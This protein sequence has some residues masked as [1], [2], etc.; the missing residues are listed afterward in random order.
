[1]LFLAPLSLYLPPIHSPS[2]VL[3]CSSSK[4][5]VRSQ[6]GIRLP[7]AP[8][9]SNGYVTGGRSS[10]RTP[11]KVYRRLDSCLV[12][13]PPS[14]RQPLAVVKF[15]G[16][17]FVGAAPELTYSLLMEL[18]AKEGF[19]IVS[20]PYGVT[21]DHSA[22]AREVHERF[23]SCMNYLLS[24][25]VPQSGITGSELHGL[26]FYSVG[27]SNGALLQMLVGSFFSEKIPKANVVIS[28]C[29]KPASQAVPYFEQ[30]GPIARQ[31]MPL[32]EASPAYSMA[33]I[34]LGLPLISFV[35]ALE[36]LGDAW[37]A[38]VHSAETSLQDL[39]QEIFT[40]L[41]KF[42][43]QLPSVFGQVTQG[44]SEFSPTPME[45]R[46]FFKKAYS[47]PHTL[48]VKFKIDGIDES[49][50]LEKVLKPRAKSIGGNVEKVVLSGNHLTP[51]IQD[52][53]W[54]VGY[55]YTPVDA[56]AQSLKS[57][58]LNE[59]KLLAATIA[60][61]LKSLDKVN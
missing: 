11:E 46:E 20:V 31:L 22:A 45:N 34:A 16:G 7:L 38:L 60:D 28:F 55:H 17:A 48:L 4:S 59:T 3:L 57:L 39:D 25:G 35:F 41:T 23:H 29:N 51:C 13:P 36:F 8:L 54:P 49:E 24:L 58:T 14:G 56:I 9:S 53:K 27:H 47:V 30:I 12:I 19:L 18:L 37:K 26:P 40:S 50:I 2:A 52:L 61:W 21:F 5:F 6:A 15:L 33:Q 32:V 43:D 42:V 44:T 1:M 10:S